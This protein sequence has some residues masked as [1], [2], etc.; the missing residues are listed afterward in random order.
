MI[1]VYIRG[2]SCDSWAKKEADMKVENGVRVF[3]GVMILISVL[4]V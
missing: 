3:A 2:H 4:L 1:L